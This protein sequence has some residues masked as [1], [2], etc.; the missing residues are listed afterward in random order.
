MF[1]LELNI[2]C[3]W[4]QLYNCEV[5]IVLSW[6]C[7]SLFIFII[8]RGRKELLEAPVLFVFSNKCLYHPI[9]LCNVTTFFMLK[10]LSTEGPS[11]PEKYQHQRWTIRVTQWIGESWRSPCLKEKNPHIH[12]TPNKPST[13]CVT[14]QQLLPWDETHPNW[15]EASVHEDSFLHSPQQIWGFIKKKNLHTQW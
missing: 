2:C 5:R 14:P 15:G 7:I 4:F 8:R 1:G 11:S 3:C 10:S 9:S 12:I 13:L 6:L